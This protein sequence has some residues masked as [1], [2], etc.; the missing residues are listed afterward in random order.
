[1]RQA[2]V[3]GLAGC[4]TAPAPSPAVRQVLAP[5]GQLR[6]ALYVGTPT[7]VLSNTD[8]RGV[9][10]DLGQELARRL[11]VP[12]APMILDKNADVGGTP[13]TQAITPEARALAGGETPKWG[14]VKQLLPNRMLL[15]D[16]LQQAMTQCQRSGCSLAVA[17]LDLDGFKAVND[18]HGH[19]AGD[20]LLKVVS[21]RLR[22]SLRARLSLLWRRAT[23]EPALAFIHVALCAID[24]ERLRGELLRVLR[25]W[26]GDGP[27]G[28]L[29]ACALN[30][31]GTLAAAS[32][33]AACLS[34]WASARCCA[35]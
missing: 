17:Y 7:S 30:P 31:A 1:M 4:A 5:T 21:D 33:A 13:G 24:L 15:A 26:M 10:Y 32:G 35:R 23:L 29:L 28:K 8:R 22:Q 20:V 25:P 9:G 19:A 12:F 34:A 11:Q 27:E 16:R 18:R 2:A 14:Y 3:I 6:V